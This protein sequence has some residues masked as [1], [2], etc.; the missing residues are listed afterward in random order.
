MMKLFVF[1]FLPVVLVQSRSQLLDISGI[2]NV[3]LWTWTHGHH[4]RQETS[5]HTGHLREEARSRHEPSLHDR[6]YKL[7]PLWSWSDDDTD[8]QRNGKDEQLDDDEDGG[9]GTTTEKSVKTFIPFN[10]FFLFIAFY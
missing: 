10:R 6:A 8:L 5:G 3:P 1:N 2:S 9:A 7:Q 4:L